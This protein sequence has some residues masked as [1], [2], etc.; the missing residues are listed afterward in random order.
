MTEPRTFPLA[1]VL[2][3]T[4]PKLLSR[5]G[6]DGLT[7]LLNWMTDDRLEMWQ[8]QRAADEAAPALVVQHPHLA[9]LVPPT[10]IDKADLYAWLVAAEQ[11]HGSELAV[12]PLTEW[13]NQDPGEELRDRIDLVN[14]PVTE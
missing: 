6:M 5:R 14:L 2:S 7:D 4:T 13:T 8:L 9:G 11:E 12:Q 1:D 3:V 10:G